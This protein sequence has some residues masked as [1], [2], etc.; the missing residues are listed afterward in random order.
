MRE[1]VEDCD[2]ANQVDTDACRTDCTV[3]ACGDGVRRTDI[4]IGQ[5]NYEA[6][7]D[8]NQ[9]DDDNCSNTCELSACGNGQIDEGET[10][11]DGNEDN[12]DACLN[13]CQSGMW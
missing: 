8:G 3:A 4:V 1:N 5:P 11:D 10:C 2:D 7:D 13:G 6:C 12:T 9:V